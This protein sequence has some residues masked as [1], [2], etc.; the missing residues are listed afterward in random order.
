M[1]N[2][3]AGT[4]AIGNSW[5]NR[6]SECEQYVKLNKFLF[7]SFHLCL[8][9]EESALKRQGRLKITNPA[10]PVPR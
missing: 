3:P 7:G 9:D 8:T 6:C 4:F 2:L 5:Y 1:R 10:P